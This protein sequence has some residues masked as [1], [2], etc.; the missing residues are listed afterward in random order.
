MMDTTAQLYEL[1]ATDWKRGVYDDITATFRAP[2]VNWI[3]RTLMANDPA[4]TRRMWGRVKPVFSTRAFGE[5][6]VAYR[7]AALAAVEESTTLPTYRFDHLDVSPVEYAELRGQ[8]ATFDIVAPRLAV[9]FEVLD[10]SLHGETL[11]GDPAD[12]RASTAP[13]P[14]WLDTDRGRPATMAPIDDLPA[15]ISETVDDIRAFHGFDPDSLPSIYRCL[16]QWPGFLN[17]LW[18][19]LTPV[20]RGEAF[21]DACERTDVLVEEF[22]ETM[23]FDPGVTPETLTAWGV[24]DDQVGEL[25]DLFAEFNGGPVATVLPAIPLFATTVDAVGERSMG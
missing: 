12:S 17:A 13:L 4:F 2:I 7:D 10:R 25:Q 5:F 22:V 16:A 14:T 23:A 15:D 8:L 3:F 18:N 24:D 11:G 19:D 20:L 6:S 9:L 1:D 21:D